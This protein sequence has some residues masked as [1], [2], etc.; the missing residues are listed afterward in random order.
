MRYWQT[1]PKTFHAKTSRHTQELQHTRPNH[2]QTRSVHYCTIRH[3]TKLDLNPYAH[4]FSNSTPSFNPYPI[5]PIMS[6][7][8]CVPQSLAL[9][10]LT[11][12]LQALTAETIKFWKFRTIHLLF[13]DEYAWQWWWGLS[14]MF[15]PLVIARHWSCMRLNSVTSC[16]RS[17]N[18]L[19][20]TNK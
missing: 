15:G 10:A 12:C 13:L 19:P 18:G 3:S 16:T 8:H 11:Y 2:I 7:A 20:V 4:H 9:D 17:P 1:F 6:L 14:G 5:N